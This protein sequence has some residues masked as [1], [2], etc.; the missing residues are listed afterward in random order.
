[1]EKNEIEIFRDAYEDTVKKITELD[2]DPMYLISGFVTCAFYSVGQVL[3]T[4]NEESREYL[5][6]FLKTAFSSAQP[7]SKE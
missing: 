7:D 5:I 4:T 2:I 1:M 3:N 6:E